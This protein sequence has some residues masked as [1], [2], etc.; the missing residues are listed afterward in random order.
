[1]QEV[2]KADLIDAANQGFIDAIMYI[3]QPA[4]KK[5]EL[6]AETENC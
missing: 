1:M 4:F 5:K 2:Q 6:D 3:K